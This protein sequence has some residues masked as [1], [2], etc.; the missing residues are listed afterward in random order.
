MSAIG[1]EWG[2]RTA[3]FQ[4]NVI[5]LGDPGR[6]RFFDRRGTR[7]HVPRRPESRQEGST[8]WSPLTLE[9][10]PHQRHDYPG[11]DEQDQRRQRE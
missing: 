9:V 1:P 6:D 10:R 4:L 5:N 2:Y 7:P 8:S 11:G 3:K